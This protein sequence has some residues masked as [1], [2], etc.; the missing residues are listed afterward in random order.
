MFTFRRREQVIVKTEA[1]P[2]QA[3]MARQPIF[4][5]QLK[6]YAYELLSRSGMNNFFDGDDLDKAA[7][8]VI[9]DS[10]MLLDFNTLTSGKRAFLNVTR[11]VLIEGWAELFPRDSL[12]IEILETVEPDAELISACRRLRDAG[13]TLALDDFEYREELEPLVELANIIKVDYLQT[14]ADYRKKVAERYG[15]RGIRMLAEKVEN[16]EMLQEARGCGY[17]MFQGFF[18]A[19]PVIISA[20]DV[21]SY[22]YHLINIVNEI[23]RPEL[24]FDGLERVIKQDM[25]LV[26]K[27]L[28]YI[29]S[30]HFG[31]RHSI[32]S[33][34]HALVLLG[35][36]D[37]RKWATLVA[38]AN[39]G[40]DKPEELVGQAIMRARFCELLAPS[41]N[42]EARSQ[43]LFLMG[44]FSLIDAVLGRPMAE[45]LK[46][47]PIADDI[48]EALLGERQG[49]GSVLEYA[50]S[51]ERGAWG[52]LEERTTRGNESRISRMYVDS[53][54]WADRSLALS[55]G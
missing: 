48:K 20:N 21:P 15:P 24:D 40:K 49:L 53:V 41:F 29:N 22:K 35:E 46:P 17:S 18:F 26:Y 30:A 5:D 34:K 37:V 7:S 8:K 14:D 11:D 9:S 27:L 28:R 23:H 31:F 45:I 2:V 16:R 43:D 55:V 6:V 10:S 25:S 50:L 38:V 3:F 19:K 1:G 13:Y 42:L 36:R 44:M 32:A 52:E 4:D 39:I 47:L 54:G 33:I 51:Y 12:V